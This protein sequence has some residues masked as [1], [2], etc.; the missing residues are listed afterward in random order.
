[1]TENQNGSSGDQQGYDPEQ[2]PDADPEMLA[3]AKRAKQPDQAEGED[4]QD[5]DDS[6]S[7]GR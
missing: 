2:D 4:D 3:S 7:Q 5:L 6:G 1:M